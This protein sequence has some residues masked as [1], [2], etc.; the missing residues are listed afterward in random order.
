[1][2]VKEYGS[3]GRWIFGI[4]GWGED[5]RCY[6]PLARYLPPRGR[7]TACD[8]PGYG[9]S[10][11]PAEITVTAV[12]EQLQAA[13]LAHA[14]DDS[15]PETV[16]GNCSGAV[17]AAELLRICPLQPQRLVLIDP[18]AFV[19]SYF[20]LFLRRGFGRVAY[21]TTFASSLGRMLTNLLLWNRRQRDTDL[22]ATF[23]SVDHDVNYRYLQVFDSLGSIERFRPL[24]SRG[25]YSDQ[26]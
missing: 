8:L 26:G 12:L 21:N 11:P 16:V 1:M 14:S 18:F 23:H 4:P 25:V 6:R 19:P 13:Y 2:F 15:P 3:G 9:L 24:R 7:L 20:K 10:A 22:M 5:H 17:L